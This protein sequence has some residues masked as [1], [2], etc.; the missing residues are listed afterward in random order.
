MSD[1]MTG[2]STS[3]STYTPCSGRDKVRTADG[4]L[5]SISGKD[6]INVS[7]L[8]LSSVLHVL[9]FLTNLLSISRITHDL[10]HSVT[11][12]PSHC[13]FQ[14]L[15]TKRTIGSGREEND[16]YFLA[17]SEIE[18]QGSTGKAYHF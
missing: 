14:D 17:P 7:P 6:V 12:Y 15:H 13:V 2:L 8:S 18:S 9:N 11:F 10:N 4:S 1:H 16:L 5:S 3:F